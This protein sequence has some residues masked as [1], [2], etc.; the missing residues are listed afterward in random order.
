MALLGFDAVGRWALG[1]LPN[2]Q[3]TNTI[4]AVD[5]AAYAIAGLPAAFRQTVSPGAMNVAWAGGDT[6]GIVGF[7]AAA[8]ICISS[9]IAVDFPVDFSTATGL[10]VLSGR[11]ALTA[12]KLSSLSSSY[13]VAGQTARW[14]PSISIES[15]SYAVAGRDAGI[16]QGFENWFQYP[17]DLDEW[18][19]RI[20]PDSG[21]LAATL[22][23]DDWSADVGSRGTW[24]AL[25]TPSA[26]W[27]KR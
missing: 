9:G 20:V 27:T 14:S 13:V 7:S 17:L 25:V 8:G 6:D 22:P 10:F 18:T 26:S 1:Q 4:F 16:I 5:R 2:K 3:A 11:P 23:A 21:W 24:N 15:G 12:M 19:G